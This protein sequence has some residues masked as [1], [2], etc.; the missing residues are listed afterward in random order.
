M[1][2][3]SASAVGADPMVRLKTQP[4]DPR[5]PGRRS[6]DDRRRPRLQRSCV[7]STNDFRTVLA[8]TPSVPRY[9]PYKVEKCQ[10]ANL[11]GQGCEALNPSSLTIMPQLNATWRDAPQTEPLPEGAAGGV[12]GGGAAAHPGQ[13]GATGGVEQPLQLRLCSRAGQHR[14]PPRPA[15]AAQQVR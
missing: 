4:R 13:L 15:R 5:R 9:G 2:N 7:T 12:S 8:F 11:L 3:G 10:S 6:V 1:D 14:F